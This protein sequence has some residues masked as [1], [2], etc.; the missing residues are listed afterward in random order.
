[1]LC[2]CCGKRESVSTEEA[3]PLCNECWARAGDDG[4]RVGANVVCTTDK[5]CSGTIRCMDD[6]DFIAIV[7]TTD[8]SD[9]WIPV[10]ELV[11]RP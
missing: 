10:C 4:V 3:T 8:G 6:S 5:S 7:K 11:V 2:E 1:M 9:A